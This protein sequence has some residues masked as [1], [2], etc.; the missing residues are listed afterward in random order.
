MKKYI[1]SIISIL[2]FCLSCSSHES[3][4]PNNAEEKIANQ[5]TTQR[6]T[7]VLIETAPVEQDGILTDERDGKTYRIHRFG[8]LWWMIDNLNYEVDG[9]LYYKDVYVG[10]GSYCYDDNPENCEKY[11]RLYDLPVAVKACPKGWR[12]PTLDE[13]SDLNSEYANCKWDRA[14]PTGNYRDTMPDYNLQCGGIGQYDPYKK[15]INYVAFEAIANYWCAE[16]RNY[17]IVYKI[18]LEQCEAHA[19][20]LDATRRSLA[21]QKFYSCRCVKEVE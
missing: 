12:L 15:V 16:L 1:Y 14:S 5:D 20:R 13:W 2:I 8:N 17:A 11:G 6:D 19:T 18:D 9:N 7:V 21:Q 4:V 10:Q 3:N